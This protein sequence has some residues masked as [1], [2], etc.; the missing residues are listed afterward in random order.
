M[1]RD[2]QPNPNSHFSKPF[3][4]LETTYGSEFKGSKRTICPAALKVIDMQEQLTK[5]GFKENS[6]FKSIDSKYSSLAKNGPQFWFF[7]LSLWKIICMYNHSSQSKTDII[8]FI[9]FSQAC[10]WLNILVFSG[11]PLFYP[12]LKS[13]LLSFV[14]SLERN[15]VFSSTYFIF[16]SYLIVILLM[17]SINFSCCL[18]LVLSSNNL[19][20]DAYVS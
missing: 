12:T 15:L 8:I 20:S 7:Y 10:I 4:N 11:L 14:K 3:S 17:A 18:L 13:W 9:V 1:G 5:S 6:N 2:N 19:F 16:L